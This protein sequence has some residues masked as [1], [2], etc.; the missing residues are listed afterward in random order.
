MLLCVI[1]EPVDSKGHRVARSF[2]DEAIDEWFHEYI[3]LLGDV[4]LDFS[5]LRLHLIIYRTNNYEYKDSQEFHTSLTQR[6]FPRRLRKLFL[7]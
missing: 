7:F 6:K 1:L 5:F 2:L 3:D 4:F